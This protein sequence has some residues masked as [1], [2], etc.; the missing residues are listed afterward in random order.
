[1]LKYAV[2]GLGREMFTILRFRSRSKLFLNRSLIS[3]AIELFF[4]VTDA[5]IVPSRTVVLNRFYIP[6]LLSNKITR[7]TPNTLSGANLLKILN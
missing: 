1:M 7:F 6:Y 2:L 3:I 4:L 5:S